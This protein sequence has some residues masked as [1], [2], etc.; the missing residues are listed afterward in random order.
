M[1][2]LRQTERNVPAK[3]QHYAEFSETF[4]PNGNTTQNFPKRSRQMATLRRIFRNVPPK[5]GH[6]GGRTFFFPRNWNMSADGL[7][8][9]PE[10]G[11]CRRTDFFLPPKLETI[12]VHSETFPQ[13]RIL[14]IIKY[15]INN[16]NFINDEN[17]TNQFQQ[18]AQR[19]AL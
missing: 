10:T 11:T 3:W 14:Q 12:V 2:T 1:A 13:S 16:L 15:I 7:F 17:K 4:P 18:I 6:V 5:L 19:G 8:S 9:S